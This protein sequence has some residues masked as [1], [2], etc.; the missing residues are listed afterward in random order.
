MSWAAHE[1]ELYVIQRHAWVRISYLGVLAGTL[2]PDVA[3]KLWVYG[4]SVGGY[5]VGVS[6]PARFHRGWPGLGFTHSLTFGLLVA[7][8]IVWRTGSRPW[9]LGLLVGQWA[10]ALTDVN[11]S[12]GTMLFFPFS[13]VH[14]STG[15]WAYAAT[16]G[17]HGDAAAYYSSLGGAWDVLWL[18]IAALSWRVLSTEHFRTRVAATDRS[19]GWIQHRFA[20]PDVVVVAVY[21]A[22]F[23]YGACRIVAWTVW[24]HTVGRSPWDLSWGGPAFVD[25]IDADQSSI[26]ALVRATAIGSAAL[27]L[28]AAVLWRLC[29]VYVSPDD[30]AR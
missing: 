24:A 19:W 23:L 30:E 7:A 29:R 17:R 27:A 12:V 18:G 20:L 6:D 15:M 16:E 9:A 21:R 2:L 25:R 10:H 1:M 4:F 22:Y 13:T 5:H 3:T 14:F 11:D 28:T 8:L 26:G